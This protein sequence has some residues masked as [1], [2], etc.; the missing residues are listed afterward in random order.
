MLREQVGGK[1]A[2]VKDPQR[3]RLAEKGKAL[4]RKAFAERCSRARAMPACGAP[5]G[6]PS[7]TDPSASS[8]ATPAWARPAP[9]AICRA[10]QA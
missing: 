8:G 4:G 6:K 3:R 9:F 5:S 1:R 7:K 2:K 10:D